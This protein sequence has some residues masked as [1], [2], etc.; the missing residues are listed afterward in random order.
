[1]PEWFNGRCGELVALDRLAKGTRRE[2]VAILANGSWGEGGMNTAAAI[3]KDAAEAAGSAGLERERW[4]RLWWSWMGG[5]AEGQALDTRATTTRAS[6]R[7][8]SADR[9]PSAHNSGQ[10]R[11]W[12]ARAKT[13]SQT[14]RLS[15]RHGEPVGG[16]LGPWEPEQRSWAGV[17]VF[18]L[19]LELPGLELQR[20]GPTQHAGQ[21]AGGSR[22]AS[23]RKNT[24]TTDRQ[25][26]ISF[27]PLS[28]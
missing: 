5:R 9:S 10:V 14:A 16:K 21:R 25:G 1:V 3:H 13:R 7:R 17:D 24:T 23:Q 26:L 12:A 6:Q 20:S 8:S 2:E 19:W 28:S 11:M 15:R 18:R 27:Q 4:A 22:P